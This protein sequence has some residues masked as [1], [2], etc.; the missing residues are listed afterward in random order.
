MTDAGSGQN[1][2]KDV[3]EN[4]LSE[5]MELSEDNSQEELVVGD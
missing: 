5:I 2:P 4:G 3:S 1:E